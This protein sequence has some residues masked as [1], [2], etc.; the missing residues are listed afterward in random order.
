MGSS[1]GPDSVEESCVHMSATHTW[2]ANEAYDQPGTLPR[3]GKKSR[4]VWGANMVDN[5]S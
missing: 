5:T 4:R 1:A 2:I 3:E